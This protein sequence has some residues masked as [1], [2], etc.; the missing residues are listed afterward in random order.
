MKGFA[1]PLPM[2]AQVANSPLSMMI[3]GE[4]VGLGQEPRQA[5]PLEGQNVQAG[6]TP[7][8][9][10]MILP[11]GTYSDGSTGFALPGI[12]G[13]YGVDALGRASQAPRGSDAEWQA[14]ADAGFE[15]A[16][17]AVTGGLGL[18]IAGGMADNAVGVFGGKLAKTADQSALKRAQDMA[19]SGVP[20]EKIWTDTGW[21]QGPNGAWKFE[22]DDSGSAVSNY[23]WAEGWKD[24]DVPRSFMDAAPTAPG[25]MDQTAAD[26]FK[27]AKLYEAYPKIADANAQ[28]SKAAE[29]GGQAGPGGFTAQGPDIQSARSIA[30]HELQHV[31]DEAEG[32]YPPRFPG[33][34]SGLQLNHTTQVAREA[35]PDL[36]QRIDAGIPAELP[37]YKRIFQS[38]ASADGISPDAWAAYDE[39]VKFGHRNADSEVAART[40]EKR[41]DMTPEDRRAR[42]PWLDYDVPEADQ[43]FAN[44]PSGA[45]VPLAL[46]ALERAGAKPPIAE[47]AARP[48]LA[49]RV[50]LE[51]GPEGDF[52][53][54]EHSVA[55]M[56]AY[57]IP[58]YLDV[59][60]EGVSHFNLERSMGSP[61]VE[62]LTG[63]GRH[64]SDQRREMLDSWTEEM[65]RTRGGGSQPFY[66]EINDD[67]GADIGNASGE[68]IGDTMYFSW[69]GDRRGD[70]KNQLGVAGIRQLREQVRKDFPQVKKF[71][72][73][74]VSGARKD[75]ANQMQSV[76]IAANAPTGAAIPLAMSGNEDEEMDPLLAAILARYAGA[77]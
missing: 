59:A 74:R 25:Y 65:T 10:G 16:G 55:Q 56:Y 6:W 17:S 66:Y 18:G 34:A 53:P 60:R 26:V 57:K 73:L 13:G 49:G 19:A 41:R 33:H 68:V 72:G 39:L 69:L 9:R 21:F 37:W 58:A 29:L 70:A 40:V 45:S 76:Y 52:E 8:D 30:L 28:I 46:N 47:G 48:N 27:H 14:L 62:A 38:N 67:A 11:L 42:P 32:T 61:V 77:Q 15:F 51:G 7:E 44:A 35:R 5:F 22:I 54:A 64:M 2:T 36:Q 63:A 23:N 31:V 12:L 1:P 24:T 43:L 20:R 50:R 75:S 71:V 3:D 4:E